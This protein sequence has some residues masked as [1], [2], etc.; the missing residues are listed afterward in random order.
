MKTVFR[1]VFFVLV[2]IFYFLIPSFVHASAYPVDAYIDFE[3]GIDGASMTSTD[4]NAS[5]HGISGWSRSGDALHMYISNTGQ[6]TLSNSV[7]VG[8]T[9]YTDA[10][11]TRGFKYDPEGAID[12][13]SFQYTFSTPLPTVSFGSYFMSNS[14]SINPLSI[15]EG[16]TSGGGDYIVSHWT[17]NS[18]GT[19]GALHIRSGDTGVIPITPNNWYWITG[20]Y[21]AGISGLLWRVTD[22]SRAC[23]GHRASAKT[24]TKRQ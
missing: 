9:V 18:G 23:S 7:Q 15:I 12:N 20:V 24:D 2:G 17:S 1:T 22:Q 8:S 6:Y 4:M 13:N 11:G 10:G 14:T 19:G 3:S 5:S 21:R 16:I